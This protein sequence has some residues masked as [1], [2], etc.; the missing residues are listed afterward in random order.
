[1]RAILTWHSIDDSGSAISTAPADLR[2]QLEWL[3]RSSVEVLDLET[4]AGGERR[5]DAVALTFDD[6]FENFET[7][8]WPLLRDLELPATM[9]VPSGSVGGTNGWESG[10]PLPELPILPWEA[11]ARMVEAG[12]VLGS[13]SATHPDLRRLDDEALRREVFEAADRIRTATGHAPRAFAYPFGAVDDRVADV[14]RAH[15]VLA[16]TTEFRLLTEDETAWRLPRLDAFYF[17]VEGR[18]EAFG[19]DAFERFVDRRRLLRKARRY[20]S[21]D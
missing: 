15:H 21:R 18:L 16:V 13:H 11:L 12:L 2:R 20:F 7:R 5:G 8:A 3:A 19:S 1:M 14:V 4:L 17:R 6:A 9:F 10:G